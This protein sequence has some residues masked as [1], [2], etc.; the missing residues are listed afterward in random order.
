[1]VTVDTAAP[2]VVSVMRQNP[3]TPSSSA[4]SITFRVTF[5]ESV[6]GVD[7][8]DFTPVFSASLAGAI[9]AV[10]ASGGKT[11][12]VTVD[13]L[14][15]EGTVRLDVN[16]GTGIA[17]AAGNPLAAGFTAGQTYARLL[18]GNGTWIR[19]ATGG[20]WGANDNWQDGIVG[21]TAGSTANFSAIEIE[22]DN[23][24]Y[25]DG[26][27]DIGNLVFGDTDVA[28]AGSWIVDDSGSPDN[29]LTLAVAG[30]SPTMTVNPLGGGSA[31]V[32]ATSVAGT[33]GLTK[34]GPGT[35]A[36]TKPNPLSGTL[37]VNAG[38]LRLP[39]GSSLNTGSGAVN[40]TV[41][42]GV[43]IHV[44][45]G[46][47]T[48]GGPMTLG[49]GG[50]GGIFRLESGSATLANVTT[51]SDF[52]STLRVDGGTLTAAAV[53]IQRNS[54]GT[55]DFNSGFIV[56][57]GSATVTTIGLGT[58]NSNG[59]LTVAGGSL[60][61]SGTITVGNQ[62]TGGRGGALRV[63][64][65]ALTSTDPVNG[66]VLARTN[67]ANANNVASATFT[68]GVSTVEKL[69]LGFDATV[70]AGSAT[71]ALNGGALYVGGGGIVRNGAGTFLSTLS[72]G[73][74]ILGA[75]AS[76]ATAV[77]ITLP[78]GGNVVL[79]AADAAD[80]PHDI[81]L[82]VLS[83]PGG[84]TKTGVGTLVLPAASSFTGAI[85]VDGGTLLVDGSLGTGAALA[86]NA[87]G[88]LAGNGTLARDVAIH[89]GGTVVAGGLAPGSMLT[90][91]NVTWNGGGRLAG[92]L[93]SGSRL[94]VT[95]SLV[96][97]LPGAYEVVLS[98]SAPLVVGSVYTLA[99]FG[100]TDFTALD[101][102]YSGLPGYRGVFLVGPTMLQFLVTGAGPT[103]EYTHWAYLELPEGQRGATDD[104]DGD[105][106][107]NLLEF[108][109][110]G[111]PSLA[112]GDGIQATTVEDGGVVYPA[113]VYQRRQALGGVTLEVHA[114]ASLAFTTLFET[115]EVSVEARGDG[116]ETVVVRS[117]VS[118]TAQPRQ[119]FR[120]AATLPES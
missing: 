63:I 105:G 47:F 120:L 62:V 106:I 87:G 72:F 19:S 25:L 60:L 36:L 119:F 21:G 57:G 95:G 61:A 107:P 22:G 58:R 114:A 75:K 18:V 69:T 91:G 6:S 39:A 33:A 79:K 16:A 86:V 52:G 97:G 51:N 7:A 24:V 115:V 70:T 111:D 100:G 84:F 3:T 23:T 14:T 34:L 89:D 30:G 118:L 54:A 65:G 96:K 83:G 5:A 92:D 10:S 108:A 31:A 80:V 15:G 49:S 41:T 35:L 13:P 82:G 48:A 66:L 53:N 73:S 29:V 11:I 116:T 77:P 90:V 71:V 56:A 117:A 40:V 102:T 67:G 2:T 9:S 64:G 98:T 85:A 93:A 46:A 38:T 42:A 26:P 103:A 109:T 55:P 44:S 88:T 27:R 99:T 101:L 12:D 50:N 32:I 68:A 20:L 59:A 94:A 8:S 113:A 1:V 28:S 76:W 78:T 45:G 104:P 74:G 37:N 110:G 81:T 4:A 43:Q 17:D 112:G